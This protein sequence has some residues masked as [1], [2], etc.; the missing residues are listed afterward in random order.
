MS[1]TYNGRFQHNHLQ[2]K[3][4]EHGEHALEESGRYPQGLIP[5]AGTVFVSFKR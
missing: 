1:I 4:D 5:G 3:H 2:E